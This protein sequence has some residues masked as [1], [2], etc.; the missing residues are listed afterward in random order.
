M[1]H[2]DPGSGR[3]HIGRARLRTAFGRLTE[4]RRARPIRGDAADLGAALFT[5]SLLEAVLRLEA[6]VGDFAHATRKADHIDELRRVLGLLL[7]V[8]ADWEMTA[9]RTG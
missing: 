1:W 4:R 2:G 5:E 3:R 6:D 9:E 8:L 7:D